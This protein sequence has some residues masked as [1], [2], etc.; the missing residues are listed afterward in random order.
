MK[1]IFNLLLVSLLGMGTMYAQENVTYQRPS[2]EILSLADY[3]RP[4]SVML[5]QDKSWMV[6]SYR[7]TYKSLDELNQEEVRLAGLRINPVTNISSTTTYVNNIKLK[8]LGSDEEIQVSGLPQQ[9]RISNTSFSP[10]GSLL[11]F[12]HTTGT[13]VEL[14]VVELATAQARKLSEADL[15]ANM[16]MPYSWYKDGSKLLVNKL[17]TDRAKLIDSSKDLPT[18]PIVSTSGGQVSQ[19]RTYQDLLKNPQ[20][21]ANFETLA[22]SELYT[23]DLNGKQEKFLDKAIYGMQAFSPDGQYLMVTTIKKP[24]SYVV[25]LYSFPQET[26][27]YDLQ[28]NLVKVVNEVPLNEIQPKG[29]SSTRKGKRG[30]YWRGD[31]AAS[32][33]YV[34]ALD[35]GDASKKVEYRDELFSW[36]A[37]FDGQPVSLTK[38][39]DRFSRVIWGDQ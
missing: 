14:W 17:P 38:V 39:A 19:L 13:G 6:L 31:K 37:P 28:G 9:V 3:Q 23:V 18:G 29:F 12:T 22:Q 8:K 4:P 11:A 26:A 21:E 27:V 33:Y 1:L 10:D 15:N 7:S 36:D 35:E 20:D 32:V 5:N 30:M 24:F 34:E 25:P 16:G 2:P